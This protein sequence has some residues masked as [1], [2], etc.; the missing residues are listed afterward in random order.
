M[1]YNRRIKH[2]QKRGVHNVPRLFV[3]MKLK[4]LFRFQL[5]LFNFLLNKKLLFTTVWLWQTI[6]GKYAANIVFHDLLPETNY[7]VCVTTHG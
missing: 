6:N 7:G 3:G 1:T 4:R 5:P 2:T